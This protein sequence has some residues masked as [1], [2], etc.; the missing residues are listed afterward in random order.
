MLKKDVVTF[1]DNMAHTWDSE[2]VRNENAIKLILKKGGIKK[3]I[4]VLDVACGTGVLFKDYIN[5]GVSSVTGIDISS[6]MVKISRGKFPHLEVICGDAETYPFEKQF[7]VVMLYN[8]FPHFVNPEK[9]FENLSKALKDNGRLSIAHGMSEKELEQC[10]S[11]RAMSVSAP[12]PSKERLAEMMSEFFTI[13]VMV[14]DEQM[15]MVSG[16]KK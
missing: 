11:S 14:S 10:H 1:F 8:A 6:E 13:D 4:D 3:G 5:I 15:Y 12:L 16:T 2:Q 7:D 9:L